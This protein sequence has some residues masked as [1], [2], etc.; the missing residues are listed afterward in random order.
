M[1][2]RTKSYI[3]IT[4]TGKNRSGEEEMRQILGV[5]S[6]LE[7]EELEFPMEISGDATP[8]IRGKQYLKG[9]RNE[10]ISLSFTVV[11]DF[12]NPENAQ[13]AMLRTISD[14]CEMSEGTVEISAYGGMGP[15]LFDAIVNSVSPRILHYKNRL[16]I[17]Y[18]LTLSPKDD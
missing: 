4:F 18:T 13:Y 6:I 5:N 10:L 11:E 9:K 2:T 8:T 12:N 1:D 17:T 14:W 15:M 3:S 7:G 16:L